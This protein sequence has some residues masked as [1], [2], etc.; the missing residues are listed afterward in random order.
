MGE[1]TECVLVP[2]GS[3]GV[4]LS[5]NMAVIRVVQNSSFDPF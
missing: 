3:V 5:T 4:T 1:E 2:V